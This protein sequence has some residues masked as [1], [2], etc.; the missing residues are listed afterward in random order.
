[1]NK[2][3]TPI[4]T[5]V[6]ETKGTAGDYPGIYVYLIPKR[7]PDKKELISCVEYDTGCEY[8]NGMDGLRTESYAE[9]IDDP[10]KVIRYSDG[11][12]LSF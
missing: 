3:E 11:K 7:E 5:L 9:N 4:G 8:D 10:V 2:I 1:M 6:T 12:D